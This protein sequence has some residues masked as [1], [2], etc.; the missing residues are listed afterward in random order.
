MK[1]NLCSAGSS[2][3]H[4]YP[5][6]DIYRCM[7]DYNT[8]RAPITSVSAILSGDNL[9]SKP[10]SCS[11]KICDVFCDADWST[12]W[13][14]ENGATVKKTPANEWDGVTRR[15]PWS[16]M[17]LDASNDP[18]FLAIVWTPTLPC[19]YTCS[20][21]G[22]AAGTK[23]ILK[24]FPSA[25]PE[26]S[27][28][29]WLRFFET[30]KEKY[31]WGYLQT[32]GGEPLLSDAT[33]P[34]FKFLANSWAINLVTN[35]SVKIMELVRHQLPV[36]STDSDNGLS[37]TLSLHPTSNGFVW[38]AFLGKALMLHNE[39]YLRGINF[40]GWSEQ[41]YLYDYYK[42]QLGKFGI[43]LSLQPWMGE[44]NKGFSG[45]TEKELKFISKNVTMSRSNNS[46][47]LG[48]YS[49]KSDYAVDIKIMDI[50]QSNNV[51]KLNLQ[52]INIGY[53]KW[54]SSDIKIGARLLPEDIGATR[55]IRE[56]RSTFP[57]P[58]VPGQCAKLTIEI[59]LKGVDGDHFSLLVDVVYENKFWF[60]ERGSE[61]LRLKLDRRGDFWSLMPSNKL[62]E[63]IV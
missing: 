39:G 24:E 44:D 36:L 41:L 21:C 17:E 61:V 51:T 35:G 47:F 60:T 30:I 4:A 27:I 45:Y 58:I 14:Q 5:N 28:S 3:I 34:V 43:T 50:T 2:Y 57:F 32:N 56:Y 40:V 18:N 16:E 20:Y 15:H 12:K 38:D 33:I 23:K 1:S 11:H 29:N 8:R 52:V 6:G 63:P 26:L 13:L 46:L 7:K 25:F 22:C 37:V 54:D 48:E 49:S 19:N 53:S 9:F 42:D 59:D 10:E 55:S 31:P 62:N